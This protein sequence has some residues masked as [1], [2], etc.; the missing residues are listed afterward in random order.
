MIARELAVSMRNILYDPI[1]FQETLDLLVEKFCIDAQ[2]VISSASVV[3]LLF[4]HKKKKKRK[5]KKNEL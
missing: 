3:N 1:V 4:I 5:K 2:H